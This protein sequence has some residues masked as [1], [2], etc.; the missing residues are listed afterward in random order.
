M[1]A[2]SHAQTTNTEFRVLE[3]FQESLQAPQHKRARQPAAALGDGG[4]AA[5]ADGG[6]AHVQAREAGERVH[7]RDALHRHQIDVDQSF[8]CMRLMR[9]CKA[10]RLST[11]PGKSK[12]WHSD[13]Q[14]ACSDCA[15]ASFPSTTQ[16]RYAAARRQ[17]CRL[18][19]QATL[20]FP[21]HPMRS[22]QPR[23]LKRRRTLLLPEARA[24]SRGQAAR[25]GRLSALSK[26]LPFG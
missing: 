17:Q 22:K 10:C 7:A 23:Q 21:A 1:S 11:D 6:A 5:A 19:H 12:A 20:S 2:G 13:V 4:E 24:C 15:A 9:S 26:V 16:V 25:H 18:S 3:T 14:H 8:L